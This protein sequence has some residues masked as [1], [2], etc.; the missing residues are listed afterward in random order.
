ML[1][2]KF[3][4]FENVPNE[5][6]AEWMELDMNSLLK[7]ELE[8]K[9]INIALNDDLSAYILPETAVFIDK[10]NQIER[11]KTYE[12]MKEIV[13]ELKQHQSPLDVMQ[14]NRLV[15]MFDTI[16]PLSLEP[17]HSWVRGY[18]R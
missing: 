16:N 13:L 8:F 10:P 15:P 9:K 4:G 5:V 3:K 6:L 1:R 18:S 2:K 7:Y 17:N 14:F 12:K 11:F